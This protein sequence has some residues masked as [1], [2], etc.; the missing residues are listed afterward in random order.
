MKMATGLGR[1]SAWQSST[2][3]LVFSALHIY[4]AQY[5][6]LLVPKIDCKFPQR[7]C[8]CVLLHSLPDGKTIY[9]I[10]VLFQKPLTQDTG[11]Q[12]DFKANK[13][14]SIF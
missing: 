8:G 11:Q 13:V 10:A 7:G 3:S 12:S 2:D 9:S 14:W 1:L 5:K 4:F 6:M